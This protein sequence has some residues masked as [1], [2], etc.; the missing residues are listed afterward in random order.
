MH[1]SNKLDSLVFVRRDEQEI[2]HQSNQHLHQVRK[3]GMK[4][5]SEDL[6]EEEEEKRP[7][8]YAIL[9]VREAQVPS[10]H[11]RVEETT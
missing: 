10:L 9:R 7:S 2:I 8:T 6:R 5:V 1:R 11:V 3:K 4:T